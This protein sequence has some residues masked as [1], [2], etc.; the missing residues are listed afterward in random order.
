M[1]QAVWATAHGHPL[2]VSTSAGQEFVRLGAHVDPF[3]VLLAPLWWLWSSP[4]SCCSSPRWSPSRRARCRSTGSAAGTWAASRPACR[5][6][7]RVPARARDAVRGAHELRPASRQLRDA[8]DPLCDLVPRRRPARP[9]RGLRAARGLDEEED[10]PSRS[11]AW[12]SGT[13]S[14]A[15]GGRRASRSSRSGWR[16]RS[17]TSP[18][19]SRTSRPPA[20]ARSPG[21]TRTWAAPRRDG[22]DALHASRRVRAHARQ[23]AQ[24]QVPRLRARAVCRPL[25]ARAAARSAPSPTSP[26]TCSPRSRSSRRSSSSTPPGSSAS[27]PRRRGPRGGAARPPG[28]AR[29]GSAQAGSARA[30]RAPRRRGARQHPDAAPPLDPRPAADARLERRARG[31]GARARADSGRRPRHRDEQARRLPLRAADDLRLPHVGA[32]RCG[33]SSNTTTR[34]TASARRS[35]PR[36]RRSR[37]APRWRTVYAKEGVVVL[38]KRPPDG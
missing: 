30:P 7:A 31:E 28:G 33:R 20:R 4:L 22:A 35:W 18:S 27:W 16:S 37:R 23:L 5:V 10:I 6:R 3:L 25:G 38:R 12:V 26:S 11:A 2:R 8:P 21:A 1:T 34:P 17:S 19:S 9:V 14:R 32:A 13:P 15:A 36:S 29:A 24:A